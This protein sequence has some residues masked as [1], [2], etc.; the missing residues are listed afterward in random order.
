GGGRGG[1]ERDGGGGRGSRGGVKEGAGGGGPG[2][3]GGYVRSREV[4]GGTRRETRPSTA[5]LLDRSDRLLL[6]ASGRSSDSPDQED[7]VRGRALSMV[8]GGIRRVDGIHGGV[9]SL[10]VRRYPDFDRWPA[11]R[12]ESLLHVRRG[13]RMV[14]H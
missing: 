14:G 1:G 13:R 9:E 8:E 7:A 2:A 5:C 6:P 12:D 4:G 10:D 3:E 11:S